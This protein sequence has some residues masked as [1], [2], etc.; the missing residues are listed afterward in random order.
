M[1]KRRWNQEWCILYEWDHPCFTFDHLVYAG[2]VLLLLVSLRV[3]YILVSM[4]LFT[5]RFQQKGG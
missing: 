2:Y 1:E 3:S 4:L 5:Y